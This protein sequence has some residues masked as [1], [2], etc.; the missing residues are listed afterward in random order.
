[1]TS[2]APSA[3]WVE[4]L[5]AAEVPCGPI[6]G[7]DEVFADPQVK[8]LGIAQG[9]DHPELGRIELVGQA[10]KLSRTPAKLETATAAAGAHNDDI[11]G[12]L[13]YDAAAI[14]AMRA[15]GVI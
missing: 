1:M 6:Y 8:H 9:V 12:E 4:K 15:E 13:G 2:N 14:A 3:F 7:M 10:I 11:L 5:N